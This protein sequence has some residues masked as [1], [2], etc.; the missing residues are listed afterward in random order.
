MTSTNL[1][2]VLTNALCCISAQAAKV[3]KLLSIGNKCADEDVIKLKLLNDYFD[4]LRCYNANTS[5]NSEFVL[6]LTYADYLSLSTSATSSL[7]NYVLTIDGIQ[8]TFVG[9]NVTTRTEAL[10]I[11]LD[12]ALPNNNYY[13]II[14]PATKDDRFVFIYVTGLCDSESI[15][16]QNILISTGSPVGVTFAWT[17]YKNGLCTV[18]NCLTESEFNIIVAKLMAACDI[19][20]CQLTQ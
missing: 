2:I 3:S 12:Q 8:Y 10:I 9:D 7:R 4:T 17:K 14:E 11:L 13:T 20:E 16:Y 1:N 19:C 5:I 6:K 15:T 18:T